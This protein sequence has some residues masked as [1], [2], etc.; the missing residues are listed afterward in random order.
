MNTKVNSF[1][2]LISDQDI[3]LQIITAKSG[4][5]NHVGMICII[6]D[7]CTDPELI[8]RIRSIDEAVIAGPTI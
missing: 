6:P 8:R 2:D 1:C 3:D 5:P 4:M 7:A